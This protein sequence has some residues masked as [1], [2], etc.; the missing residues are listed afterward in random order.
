[1]DNIDWDKELDQLQRFDKVEEAIKQAEEAIK[2]SDAAEEELCEKRIELYKLTGE[3]ANRYRELDRLYRLA[4]K[5]KGEAHQQAIHLLP[6]TTQITYYKE[7][8]RL[9]ELMRGYLVEQNKITGRIK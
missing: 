6:D 2:Q 9:T 1:M 4:E 3:K 8:K 7:R 5:Q